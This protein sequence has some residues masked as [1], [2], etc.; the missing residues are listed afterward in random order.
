MNAVRDDIQGSDEASP[1]NRFAMILVMTAVPVR[2]QETC[3]E[4]AVSRAMVRCRTP[5]KL[6]IELASGMLP[7]RKLC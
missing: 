5:P 2:G 1:Y 3:F 6:A 7:R 4:A